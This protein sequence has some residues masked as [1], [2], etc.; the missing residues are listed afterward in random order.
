MALILG[1]DAGNYM[2]KVVGCYGEETFRTS[3]CEWFER[4]IHENFGEDDMEFIISGRRGYSGTIASYEDEFGIG[5]VY[6]DTKAHEDTKIRVLLAIY[7]YIEKYCPGEEN[8]KIVTGQPIV[9][10]KEEE[11]S[12]IIDMLIGGHVLQVNGNR[13]KVNVK[14]VKV[15]AEGSSAFWGD[16]GEGKIR[17]IDVGSGTVN[18]ATIENRKHIHTGSG[19][20]NF[21]T[22]TIKNPSNKEGLA[23]GIVRATTLL[24]WDREDKVYVC[25]GVAEEVVCF[26]RGQY[27]NAVE[28]TPKLVDNYG[29]IKELEPIYA[30]A[31]GFYE[32]AKMVYG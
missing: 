7:R 16:V 10:H 1:V 14:D 11:K 3:L 29:S 22:E 23:R 9:S 19:T 12:K 20:F 15:G 31:V 27:K 8:V 26:I 17:I 28:L 5:S 18:C 25:G 13:V 2:G 32:L 30:N 6:G 21:G 4:D 24:K